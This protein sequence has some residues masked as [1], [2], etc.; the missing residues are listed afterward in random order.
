M[1][2]KC[3]KIYSKGHNSLTEDDFIVYEMFGYVLWSL[4][5]LRLGKKER[6]NLRKMLYNLNVYEV[7]RFT[8]DLNKRERGAT[9]TEFKWILEY[10]NFGT[11]NWS[12]MRIFSSL[13]SI[14][15]LVHKNW[16]SKMHICKK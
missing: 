12:F 5:A 4:L 7:L 8:E 11:K 9:D 6:K 14:S 13:L 3:P 15:I 1:E 16:Y 10:Q 2:T